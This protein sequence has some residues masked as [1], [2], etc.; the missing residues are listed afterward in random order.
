MGFL[1]AV[2]G[3]VRADGTRADEKRAD[4]TRAPILLGLSNDF[5]ASSAPDGGLTV[6]TLSLGTTLRRALGIA[7]RQTNDNNTPT[8]KGALVLKLGTAGYPTL[9]RTLELEAV[10]STSDIANA[11][12][13][14]FF[15]SLT[16][17]VVGSVLVSASLTP[18]RV[19]LDVTA[20]VGTTLTDDAINLIVCRVFQT[21]TDAA[22]L[23]ICDLAQINVGYP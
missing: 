12:R 13:V 5:I 20:E 3:I 18:V 19:T 21:A 9:N 16:S 10:L 7:G 11:A 15:N 22:E 4:G 1:P 8:T 2:V 14:D 23:A 6:V 17:Q